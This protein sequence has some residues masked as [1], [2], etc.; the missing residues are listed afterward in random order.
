MNAVYS[1]EGTLDNQEN[2]QNIATYS[3]MHKSKQYNIEWKE[4]KN[5]KCMTPFKLFQNKL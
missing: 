2:E 4:A 5:F 3:N 1:C